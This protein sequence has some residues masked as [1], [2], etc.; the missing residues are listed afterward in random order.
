MTASTPAIAR[1]DFLK[2]RLAAGTRGESRTRMLHVA[3]AVVT[4]R[5]DHCRAIADRIATMPGTEIHGIEGS[6]IVVV[7]ETG[8][9][10]EIGS[11][12]TEMA[13][14]DGVFSANLVFEQ[15][16]PLN[17]QGGDR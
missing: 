3:S 4:A 16:A 11:R 6:K 7:M 8:N 17:D 14:R 2:G 9:S 5:P 10:G 12:L 13:L 1:R 15:I